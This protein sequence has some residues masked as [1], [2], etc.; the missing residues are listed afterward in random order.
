MKNIVPIQATTQGHVLVA[1]IVEDLVLTKEGGA[2]IVLK[3]PALN[4]SLLSSREQE[5]ITY[6]YSA[7]LNSLSFPI[8]IL[9][10]SQR[11]DVSNYLEFLEKQEGKQ[12]NP[13]LRSLMNSYRQFVINTVKRKNVLEKEFFIIIPFSPYE[14]GIS[15]GGFLKLVSPSKKKK[16]PYAKEYIIKKAKTVLYPRRDHLVRQSGRLGLKPKQLTSEE[17]IGLFVKLYNPGG[18]KEENETS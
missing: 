7:L 18:E 10:R 13:K 16:I 6:A 1:D 15:A 5:A 17:L 11:K 3:S 12:V 14:L 4:F 8:Q 2:A 9:I